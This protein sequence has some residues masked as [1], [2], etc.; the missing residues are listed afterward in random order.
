MDRSNLK[1][2]LAS[3]NTRVLV[4]DD[5]PQSV[6]L[7]SLYLSKEGYT[8]LSGSQGYEAVSKARADSPDLILLDVRMPELDGYE[9]TRQLKSDPATRNIPIILITALGDPESKIR[10]FDAGADEFLQKP[11]DHVELLMRIRSMLRLK[12]YQ[13]QLFQRLPLDIADGVGEVQ[14]KAAAL[15]HPHVVVFVSDSEERELV[16]SSLTGEGYRVSVVADRPNN[17]A[18]LLKQNVDFLVTDSSIPK[19]LLVAIRRMSKDLLTFAVVPSGDPELRLRLLDWGVSELL[20]HPFNPRE[21]TLRVSRVRKQKLALRA[22]ELRYRNAL[23]AASMDSMTKI[24]NHGSFERFLDLEVKRSQRHKHPT[25]LVML[26]IDDFKAKNDDFGHAAGDEILIE[27]ANRIRK[28]VREIDL[29]ARYGGEEF[30]VV[31]PYTNKG[32]AAV[33]AERIRAAIA[34][35]EFSVNGLSQR[36]G[37]T[38]SLGVAVCPDDA[39]SAEE[40]IRSAD[41]LLYRAKKFGKNKVCTRS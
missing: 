34:A 37:V 24:P 27:V 21:L 29:T 28:S 14:A 41:E 22:L 25:S 1:A 19:N 17:A 23:N 15:E 6:R 38:V 13:E 40:L 36:V 12:Q 33:V 5:D 16:V 9:A 11:I 30:A 8:V 35:E 10:G 39:A 4:V 20:V 7:F 3:K 18:F 26:D 32:G 31:L 2:V